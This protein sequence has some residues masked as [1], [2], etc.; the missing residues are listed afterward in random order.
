MDRD[1][2][3]NRERGDYTWRMEDFEILDGVCEAIQSFKSAGFLVIIITNQGGIAKG[4]YQAANV[5]Q[6][7]EYLQQ[8]CNYQVDAQFFSP[9]H[10][11]ISA[12]LSRKPSSYLFERAIFKHKIEP[13]LSWMVGDNERDLIPA[14]KLNLRTIQVE[15]CYPKSDIANFHS[16]NLL[17]A[18]KI[19]LEN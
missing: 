7:F 18:S 12:S 16:S 17:A 9:Y 3:I 2:V 15:S 11:S 5:I 4:L 14:Q 19:I 6:C 1:G 8:Q 13:K 10:P